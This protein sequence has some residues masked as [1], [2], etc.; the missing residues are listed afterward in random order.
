MRIRI[1][2][3]FWNF[4]LDMQDYDSS[5]RVDFD[6]LSEFLTQNAANPIGSGTYEGTIVYASINPQKSTD[7]PLSDF[8]KNVLDR[9][10]GYHV[11]VFERKPAK[12]VKCPEC[13]NDI[14]VCPHCNK[15]LKR[16]VEKGV[17][18][19]IATDMLQLAWDNTYDSAVLLTADKDFIPM[20]E[21]LQTRGKKIIHASFGRGGR[22]LA[23][24]CWKQID[25]SR[26]AVTLSRKTIA[27]AASPPI[28]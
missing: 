10:V 4:T 17:D 3:D 26:H 13:K 25:L 5:Y 23:N 7:R 24:S 2:M 22:D 20:V 21:F 27:A 15:I 8:L 12:P 1:F 11:K 6:K 16:T 19:A 14:T 18:A 28:S 9:K